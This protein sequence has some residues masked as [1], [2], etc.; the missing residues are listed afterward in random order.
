MIFDKAC[1]I[2]ERA[3]PDLASIISKSKLFWF[4][5]K[6]HEFL[7]KE[8][9]NKDMEFLSEQ[10]MLPFPTVAIEDVGGIVILTDKDKNSKGINNERYYIDIT[11]LKT[12]ND[13]YY[14]FNEEQDRIHKAMMKNANIEDKD[15]LI[16][17]FG[18]IEQVK[19][20]SRDKFYA[21]GRIERLTTVLSEA[22]N[23]EIIFADYFAQ[24]LRA[25][26]KQ[27]VEN[28]LRS[29]LRNAM[30]AIQEVLYANTPNRFILEE[31]PM[32]PRKLKRGK[33]LRSVDRPIYTLLSPREIRKKMNITTEGS[34]DKQTRIFLGRRAHPRTY[35]DQRYINMKGKTVMIPAVWPDDSIKIIGNKRYKVM[36]DL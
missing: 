32:I 22:K 30:C 34:V 24:Q 25:L 26:P 11:R 18:A 29:A 15:P 23:N 20:V 14:D 13:A 12:D 7:P 8:L 2:A 33:I 3:M 16:I 10:F 9:N 19:F 27:L 28:H 36:L 35:L 1:K 6:P 21:I 17:T 5:G 4:P 31:S